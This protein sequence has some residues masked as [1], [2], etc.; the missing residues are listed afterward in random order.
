V[1]RPDEPATDHLLK[2]VECDR[3]FTCPAESVARHG[4]PSTPRC[5]RCAVA[6]AGADIAIRCADCEGPFTWTI[7]EQHFYRDR[8]LRRPRRCPSCRAQRRALGLGEATTIRRA[9]EW[10]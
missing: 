3:W 8:G 2:C 6:T 4:V 7:G 5:P 9:H 10:D 1:S